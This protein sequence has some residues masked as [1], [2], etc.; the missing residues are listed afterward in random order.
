VAARAQ[1]SAFTYQ[2][3]LSLGG[4]PA[5]GLFNLQFKLYNAPSA[6]VQYG[7]PITTNSAPVTNGLFTVTLDFGGAVYN[8]GDRWLEIA[9]QGAGDTNYA[10]LSPRQALAATPYA[11]RAANF[12][13]TVAAT[14]L[15][16][17]LPDAQLSTNVVRLNTSP[18]FSGS[19]T[20]SNF[21]GSGYGLINLPA[22]S[23]TG[24]ISDA[25]LSTNIA[26]LNSNAV[27]SASVAAAQFHGNGEGLTNVPG[28]I[29]EVIPVST[30]VQAVANTGYL[31]TNPAAAVVI[32]LPASNNISVGETVR[33]SGS[34]AGGWI[35]AQNAG[36]VILMGNLLESFGQTW[37]ARESSRAWRSIAS[38]A[39]GAKLAAVVNAGFIYTSTDY[40]SN[41]T[42]RASAQ[43]WRAVA[44]SG[45]GTKLAA[46]IN[47]SFAY[48]STDSGATWTP[49]SPTANWTSVA[50]SL[51]GTKYVACAGS[52]L[53]Y[54]STDSGA[55]W[56]PRTG[57]NANW[58]SVA[59]SANGS[60]LVA[61]LQGGQLYTSSN[62][63]G[64]WIAR[65]SVRAW[66]AVASSADGSRLLAA[67]SSGLLHASTDYGT[68]WTAT[69]APSLAWTAVASSADGSRLAAVY[70]LGGHYVSEDSGF[71]WIQRTGLSGSVGW[72]SVAMSSDASTLAAA[73]N[74]SQ[75]FV[76]T[77][78]A[79]TAGT[80]GSLSGARLSA[81]ELQYA[82][83]GV[84]I[85]ISSMGTIRAR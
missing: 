61:A 84:F 28:R 4:A 64:N 59:S 21:N 51:D 48:N 8:G 20:A 29:F 57:A 32:T 36:Q 83:N 31:A 49:R 18:V 30:N 73:G 5:N 11:F 45:D 24:T 19:V 16:G 68:N 34:G 40:G 26:R 53:I 70:N 41:W 14:N 7:L 71:T 12:S 55:T 82:G 44:S 39:D 13:G 60:N 58:V 27:F 3:V 74:P 65:D 56:T 1:T 37:T 15:T 47:G 52:G 80:A 38:S 72:T 66:S 43:N 81:V 9:V 62:A 77:Q 54:T 76:S 33:V 67:V 2:G 23:L 85:P 69:S 35:I 10:T 42:A 50:A 75:I 79:T 78:A 25:R 46:V 63:G 22:A 6:G 17:T